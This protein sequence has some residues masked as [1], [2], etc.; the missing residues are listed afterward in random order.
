M[1]A[2]IAFTIAAEL[3]FTRYVTVFDPADFLGHVF[4]IFSFYAIYRAVIETGLTWPY[5][6]LFRELHSHRA[7]LERKVEERT[8]ALQKSA[9]SLR[10][11]VAERRKAEEELLRE[12]AV[13]RVLTEISDALLSC[14]FSIEETGELIAEAARELTG[15]STVETVLEK[16]APEQEFS[17]DAL[18]IPAC[19]EGGMVGQIILSGKPDGFHA[20]DRAAAARLPGGTTGVL[21][22]RR[23]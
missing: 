10:A 3:C 7:E 9:D 23:R 19:L 8:A 12:L 6:M 11:E 13:N 20:H 5:N 2:A 1:Q 18:H 22:C 16:S 14:S 4:R 17:P 15:C 21:E